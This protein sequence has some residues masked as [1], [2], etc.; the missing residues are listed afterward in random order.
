MAKVEF[1][2]SL[3]QIHVAG[4]E[5]A[6]A[7]TRKQLTTSST[8]KAVPSLDSPFVGRRATEQST[9]L[10]EEKAQIV[11]VS[12]LKHATTD[13]IS[14]TKRRAEVP[15][16]TT[17]CIEA[18]IIRMISPADTNGANSVSILVYKCGQVLRRTRC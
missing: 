5:R 14:L 17:A 11:V 18:S 10:R 6:D 16:C 8:T 13:C 7:Y 4:R 15:A 3:A 12:R 2:L 1:K 9:I